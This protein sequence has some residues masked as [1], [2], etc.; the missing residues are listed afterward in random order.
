MQGLFAGAGTFD[1]ALNNWDVSSVTDMSLMFNATIHFNSPINNW[2]VSNVTTMRYMFAGAHAFNQSLN[3]WDVSNLTDLSGA[4]QGADIF[5][6]SLASWDT[7]NITTLRQTFSSAILFN[8][9]LSTWDTSSVTD[10][11]GVFW[12][13]TAF[14]QSIETWNVSNVTTMTRMFAGAT[15][16]DQPLGQ[17]N[18]Q[19]VAQMLH[20]FLDT[21][22]STPNY[23]AT[24]TGWS[25]QNVKDNVY[26]TAGTSKYCTSGVARTHL[27][28]DKL[29]TIIDSGLGCAAEAPTEPLNLNGTP[30]KSIVTLTWDAPLDSGSSPIAQYNIEYK[31][32]SDSTW[33]V[34]SEPV[35]YSGSDTTAIVTGFTNA[36][37]YDFRVI[38]VNSE[39]YLVGPS[40]YSDE[41]TLTISET[42]ND[43][44][45]GDGSSS[46]PYQINSC[47]QLQLISNAPAKSY[48]LMS[49]IDCSETINWNNGKGFMPIFGFTGEYFDGRNHTIQDLF[50]DRNDIANVAL[51]SV[52]PNGSFIKNVALKGGSITNRWSDEFMGG[53]TAAS[54]VAFS[55]GNISNASSSVNIFGYDSNSIGGLVG[56]NY[57]GSSLVSASSSG[58]VIG[59]SEQGVRAGGLTSSNDGTIVDSYSTSPVTVEITGNNVA[60]A[61]CGGIAGDAF[62]S[63][64]SRSYSTGVVTCPGTNYTSGGLVGT[65][66]NAYFE[67]NFTSSVIDRTFAGHLGSVVGQDTSGSYPQRYINNY[68]D[69]GLANSNE[70]VSFASDLCTGVNAGSTQP[71]YFKNSNTNAPLNTWDFTNT[72]LQNSSY[73]ILRPATI[74]P[75]PPE[76]LHISSENTAGIANLNWDSPS[77]DG[78][79]PINDFL[80]E[81]RLIGDTS[82]TEFA[83]GVSLNNDAS[84]FDLIPG[85]EYQFRVRAVNSVGAGLYARTADKVNLN[86]SIISPVETQFEYGDDIGYQILVENTSNETFDA[87]ETDFIPENIDVN[88]I[89]ITNPST[90]QG[91]TDLGTL[92]NNNQDWDGLLEPDQTLVFDVS[93]TV[94]GMPHEIGGLTFIVSDGSYNGQAVPMGDGRVTSISKESKNFEILNTQTDFELITDLQEDSIITSGDSVHLKYTITNLGPKTGFFT[95]S[96]VY[97][98]FPEEI[99]VLSIQND[100]L[101]CS[102]P[103][104]VD[105]NFSAGIFKNLAGNMFTMCVAGNSALLQV[106]D[107]FDINVTGS[108]NTTFLR[109][110]ILS[111]S[112]F[113]AEQDVDNTNLEQAISNTASGAS[114]IFGSPINNISTLIYEKDPPNNVTTTTT[115]TLPGTVTT[116]TRPRQ[117]T[118]TPGSKDSG[119]KSNSSTPRTKVINGGKLTTTPK[120]SKNSIANSGSYDDLPGVKALLQG[121]EDAQEKAG[122]Q[123]ALQN[124]KTADENK[125][126]L[127]WLLILVAIILS[128]ITIRQA[129][130]N[131][132]TKRLYSNDEHSQKT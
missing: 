56:R 113:V 93:G 28:V 12:G 77:Y 39:N 75:A 99:D 59:T 35:G 86:L 120:L 18:I 114:S 88:N 126:S 84:V 85:E 118:Q 115:T 109:D 61:T 37:D 36:G 78:G 7:S 97:I 3:N 74:V 10:M 90:G 51:F 19:N 23:D 122:K 41:L 106:N 4:F 68:F 72:W 63:E 66:Q 5:N 34:F 57:N 31:L 27:T 94:D 8:S 91:A 21:E 67:N 15:A 80:V 42:I 45:P 65:S 2:D 76:N 119:S 130:Q 62:D 52:L 11:E 49:N 33:T 105:N 89:A 101:V 123:V 22:L 128:I 17:W 1:Q 112:I 71:N 121:A 132:K 117:V 81:Y 73:P 25:A 108:A 44:M 29:W 16:F 60:F 13:A 124:L 129:Q 125:F 20:M 43:D 54:L 111:R 107:S 40:P 14:N 96:A 53:G 110:D 127:L 83:D 102:V 116:T 79:S 55:T 82:W 58:S 92:T 64:I 48:V 9:D 46:D 95:N 131:A 26:F 69:A 98:F 38:A 32:H 87:F 24:L 30:G 50:I 100:F 104:E 6:Q 103:L 70:C 47:L